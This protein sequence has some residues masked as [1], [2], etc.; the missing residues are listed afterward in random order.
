MINLSQQ[1]L[2]QNIINTT[3]KDNV[4]LGNYDTINFLPRTIH[5]QR[6]LDILV[7]VT[8]SLCYPFIFSILIYC[9]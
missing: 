3:D 9:A 5:T 4:T 1:H 8:F 7:F 2:Y 6:N